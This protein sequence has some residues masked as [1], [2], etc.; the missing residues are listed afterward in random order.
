MWKYVYWG[1]LRVICDITLWSFCGFLEFD[2]DAVDP[3]GLGLGLSLSCSVASLSRSFDASCAPEP[4]SVLIFLSIGEVDREDALL[5]WPEFDDV[6][7][8]MM[9]SA[10]LLFRDVRSQPPVCTQQ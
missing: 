5:F 10:S 4:L 8:D 1:F 6:V 7:I 9:C 3:S 2:L